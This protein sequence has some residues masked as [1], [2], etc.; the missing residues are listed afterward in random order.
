MSIYDFGDLPDVEFDDWPDVEEEGFEYPRDSRVDAAK[1][2]ITE[3]IESNKR[4]IFHIQQLEVLLEKT[5]F[6]WITARGINELL[7]EGRLGSEEEEL[8]GA[9]KVKFVFHKSY[10][11]HKTEVKRKIEIIRSYSE[12]E[13]TRACG[14][15]AE[16]LFLNGLANRGF[17]P[18]GQETNEYKGKKW[19]ESDH[20]LDFIIERDGLVYGA[21]VKNKLRYIDKDELEL[22]LKMCKF[23]GLKPLFIM[24]Y[25]PKTYNN[26]IIEEGGYAM[27]YEC[28]IYPFGRRS[29]AERVKH[30]LRLPVDSPRAIPE[31]IIKR[32]EKW[33]SKQKGVKKG[34]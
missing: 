30:E 31:G 26:M 8:I 24:R 3:I 33:H 17:L 5:F 19:E 4:E 32:F 2:A 9:T 22:K 28:Q 6:H 13:F 12:T 11:F 18:I 20:N 23:L 1:V 21:E 16:V 29:M 34:K 27:I 7:T 10:R 25:S 15:Q 14:M